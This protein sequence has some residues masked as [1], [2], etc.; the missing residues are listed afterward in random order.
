M[1]TEKTIINEG[2]VIELEDGYFGVSY[3]DGKSI[4]YDFI[5]IEDAIIYNERL[6]KKPIDVLSKWDRERLVS[7]SE[8]LNKAKF[9]KV[10]IT[11][12]YNLS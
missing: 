1:K 2:V 4:A 11:T 5:S 6:Y 12:T 3:E 10:K 8:N 9:R 7:V